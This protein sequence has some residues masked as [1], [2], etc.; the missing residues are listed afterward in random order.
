MASGTR[1]KQPSRL[2]PISLRGIRS[3]FTLIELLVVFGIMVLLLAILFPALTQARQSA[4]SLVCKANLKM[5]MTAVHAYATD[6]DGYV[7]PSYNMKGVTGAVSRP[8]DGWAPILDQG[9]FV[10]GNNTL[11]NNP[12]VCPDTVDVAGMA[13]TQTGFD[14]DNP[15]GYMDWPSAL[16]LSR[17]FPRKI[18]GRGFDKIIRVAYWIN[19]ANPL[20]APRSFQQGAFFTGSAGYGIPLIQR[21]MKLNRFKDFKEPAR[22]VALADGLYSGNQ[23]K[24]RIGTRDSRIGYRHTGRPVARANVG[25]ADG[26]VDSIAGDRFPRKY[27]LGLPINELRQENLGSL[28]TVYSDPQKYLPPPEDEG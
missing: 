10:A 11:R 9:G 19:G 14:P 25:F 7:V 2:Q 27:E 8:F 28:P 6:Y 26:H 1:E 3:G 22:L 17:V 4:R 16:T 12:F 13:K 18:P 5:L 24:T 20:G 15:K 23:E 21:T